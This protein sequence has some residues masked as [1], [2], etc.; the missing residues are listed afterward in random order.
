MF[1]PK[2]RVCRPGST[3]TTNPQCLLPPRN[4]TFVVPTPT[5]LLC[6]QIAALVED[7]VNRLGQNDDTGG[8][9]GFTED[10][11]VSVSGAVSAIGVEL[12][13]RIS[14]ALGGRSLE[15]LVEPHRTDMSGLQVRQLRIT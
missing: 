9:G 15:E 12:R 5:H 2:H 14:H 4:T 10:A 8:S 11:F 3:E 1:A 6:A 7:A 13:D